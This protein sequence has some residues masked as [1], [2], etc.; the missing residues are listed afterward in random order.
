[1]VIF[2]LIA[3]FQDDLE[4]CGEVS[5][6]AKIR[7]MPT[8]WFILSKLF[9][10]IDNVIVRSRETRLY[11]EFPVA[12]DLKRGETLTMHDHR[13]YMEIIWREK[14]LSIDGPGSSSTHSPMMT[15]SSLGASPLSSIQLSSRL[16]SN[17][18]PPPPFMMKKYTKD[19]IN[20]I[21]MAN[22]NEGIH[23]FFVI[24]INDRQ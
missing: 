12:S 1:L 7:V 15:S 9:V 16:G 23:Q 14:D 22:T 3:L 21:P 24:E 11:Y 6:E 10:R 19:T 18:L 2:C 17:S 4:D 8:C 5:M 13:I 20:E